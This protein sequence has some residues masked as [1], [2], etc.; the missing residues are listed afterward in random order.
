[1]IVVVVAVVFIGAAVGMLFLCRRQKRNDK[2][3]EIRRYTS[4]R[5]QHPHSP[6]R[7]NQHVA[8][9][10]FN[11]DETYAP[12]NTY[13]P[14]S[15]DQTAKYDAQNSSRNAP[16]DD[17]GYGMP[18]APSTG[19]AHQQYDM[20]TQSPVQGDLPLYDR[21]TEEEGYATNSIGA[22]D[23]ASNTASTA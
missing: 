2:D 14:P 10:S 7:A 16:V 13:A 19:Q 4:S 21:A 15:A 22:Y 8:N 12:V 6:P 3:R 17:P 23:L 5:T 18:D 9:E 11:N 20:A 1:M